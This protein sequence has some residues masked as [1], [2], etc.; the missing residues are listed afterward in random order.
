PTASPTTT[1]SKLTRMLHSAGLRSIAAIKRARGL[2]RS[3]FTTAMMLSLSPTS[4]RTY[5]Y[6]TTK[7]ST[8]KVRCSS[9]QHIIH[10]LER[11][12]VDDPPT[13]VLHVR[14][15]PYSRVQNH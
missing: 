12:L 7:L 3:A 9:T 14:N 10:C 1:A 6:C 11:R 8:D 5:H 13:Q 2:S 15:K 4:T